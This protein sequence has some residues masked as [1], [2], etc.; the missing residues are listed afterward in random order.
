VDR[1]ALRQV[2]FEYFHFSRH[3]FILLTVPQSSPSV[4]QGW[5]NK[6]I[7]DRSNSGLGSTLA[8]WINKQITRKRMAS[9]GMLHRVAFVRS[10]VSE[11]LSASI[12]RVTRFGELET[13]AVTSNR[14]TICISSQRA[15]VAS[16]G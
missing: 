13:L 3:S 4:I 9:S 6:P 16:Y 14:R 11:E 12:I 10:Y 15:S 2:L 8:P 5:Y 1:A 7:N